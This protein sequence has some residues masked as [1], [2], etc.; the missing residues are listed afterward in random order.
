ML[1]CDTALSRLT[2]Q[3]G[4]GELAGGAI[5]RITLSRKRARDTSLPPPPHPGPSCGKNTQ[6]VLCAAT[7]LAKPTS[8]VHTLEQPITIF[9]SE[10][11]H[12]KGVL[13]PGTRDGLISRD[14]RRE[15]RARPIGS[16]IRQVHLAQA[17]CSMRSV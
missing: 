4:M 1:Y 15:I 16:A 2:M 6:H 12:K 17:Y 10:E 5:I 3:G 9:I 14:R 11:L 8:V 7:I 13:L